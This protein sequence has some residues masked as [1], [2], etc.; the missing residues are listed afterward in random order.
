M[1]GSDLTE[2]IFDNVRLS[3]DNLIGK[4]GKGWDTAIGEPLICQGLLWALR[5]WD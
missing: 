5:P 4:E 2:L 1:I 3:R